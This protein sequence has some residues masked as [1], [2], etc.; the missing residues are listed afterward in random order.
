MYT[1]THITRLCGAII[2][3]SCGQGLVAVVFKRVDINARACNSDAKS[4]RCDHFYNVLSPIYNNITNRRVCLWSRAAT[5]VWAHRRVKRPCFQNTTSRYLY[6]LSLPLRG[7]VGFIR[8][9]WYKISAMTYITYLPTRRAIH[10]RRG[11]FEIFLARVILIWQRVGY[12]FIYLYNNSFSVGYN[13][14]PRVRSFIAPN[15]Y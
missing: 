4:L 12:F 1:Y 8:N 13:R 5:R 10:L 3:S 6:R 11:V 9:L 2:H 7:C 14:P 15:W